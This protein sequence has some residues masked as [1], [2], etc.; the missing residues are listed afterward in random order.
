MKSLFQRPIAK[1][2]SALMILIPMSFMLTGNIPESNIPHVM[3]LIGI[4]TGYLFGTSVKDKAK[5]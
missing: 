1:V 4:A 5:E 3:G 2:T